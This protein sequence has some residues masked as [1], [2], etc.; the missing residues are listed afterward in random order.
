MINQK[1][2]ENAN[3]QNGETCKGTKNEI[4]EEIEIEVKRLEDEMEELLGEFE[5]INSAANAK[6][7]SIEEKY[8]QDDT[9]I[10]E[11]GATSGAAAPKDAEQMDPTGEISKNIFILPDG[12]AVKATDKLTLRHKLQKGALEMN[13]TPGVHTSLISIFQMSD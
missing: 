4:D 5:T 9:G 12:H 3:K 6:L 7:D 10:V 8:S 2:I 11:T 1:K 13:V